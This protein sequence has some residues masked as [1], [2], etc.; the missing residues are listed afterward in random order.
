LE[1]Y[2]QSTTNY[3][4]DDWSNFLAMIKFAYKN[5][6]HSLTQQTP[7]FAIHGLHPKFDIEGAHKV[8]SLVIEDRT[9]WLVDI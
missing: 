1:Q 6:V 2:L 7:F 5:I 4:K 8:V 9:M 3:H